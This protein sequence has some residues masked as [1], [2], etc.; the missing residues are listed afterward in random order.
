M[1]IT[2][3]V[4]DQNRRELLDLS[5]RNRLLSIPGGAHSPR[6]IP[7]FDE[8]AAEIFRLLVED[9]KALGFLPGKKGGKGETVPDSASELPD[10][11]QPD[12]EPVS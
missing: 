8:R 3:A 11:P 10:L 12:E 5:A 1:P 9:K 6:M 2:Q 4:L 7:F